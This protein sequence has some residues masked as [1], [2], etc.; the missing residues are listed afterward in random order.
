MIA[1]SV[2]WLFFFWS[3][4]FHIDLQ[5]NVNYSNYRAWFN[6]YSDAF[7]EYKKRT[8]ARNRLRE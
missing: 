8:L 4:R 7:S 6:I 1:L 2:R 5:V 3:F